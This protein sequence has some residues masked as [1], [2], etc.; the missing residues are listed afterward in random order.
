MSYSLLNILGLSVGIAGVIFAILYW[1]NETAYDSWNPNKKSAYQM[2]NRIGDAIWSSSPAP[3][4]AELRNISEIENI[5]YMDGWYRSGLIKNGDKSIYT[6]NITKQILLSFTIF[7][8]PMLKGDAKTALKVK[9]S[10]VLSEKTA[11]T[12]FGVENPIGKT[13]VFEDSTYTITGVYQ[14]IKPSSFQPEVIIDGV[15][16]KDEAND[17]NWGNYNHTLFIKLKDGASVENTLAKI[18]NIFMEKTVKRDAKREG[19]TPEAL[20]KKMWRPKTYLTGIE[21]IRLHNI[22]GNSTPEGKWQLYANFNHAL[23]Y[24]F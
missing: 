21:R 13:L 22:T 6:K 2:S 12:F 3:L 15:I 7:P 20:M 24:Q 14:L 23:V 9:N 1:N 10:M 11:A 8:F 5:S 17:N 19:I 4:G 18:D 16:G